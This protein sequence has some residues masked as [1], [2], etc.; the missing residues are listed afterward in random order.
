MSSCH[1]VP[2]P[3]M[4]WEAHEQANV[5][6]ALEAGEEMDTMEENHIDCITCVDICP[7]SFDMTR[8]G[9]TNSPGFTTIHQQPHHHHRT[10]TSKLLGE[11]VN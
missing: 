5:A 7:K 4:A 2:K 1:A 6:L 3:Q 8:H 11:S 10:A 9:F